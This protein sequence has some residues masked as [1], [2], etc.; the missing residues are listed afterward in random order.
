M[1]EPALTMQDPITELFVDQDAGREAFTYVLHSGR[2]GTVHVEHAA[3]I[4]S[5][6]DVSQGPFA[7]SADTRSPE[8][9][10][11]EP[12]IQTRDRSSPRDFRGAT[13]SPARSDELPQVRRPAPGAAAG[14]QLRF[15]PFPHVKPALNG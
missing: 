10:R 12:A 7:L 2:S 3:R 8:A 11:D 4:Q 6:P 1:A 15:F 13:L 5:G 9:N 14:S